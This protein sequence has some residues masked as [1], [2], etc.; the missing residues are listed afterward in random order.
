MQQPPGLEDS[1]FPTHVYKLQRALYGL[2][3]S[4]RGWYAQLSSLLHQLGFVSS[5]VDTCLFIY[6][7][8]D[9][10]LYMLV[11][12]DG[13]VIAGS[14]PTAVDRL[15]QSLSDAFSIKDL[16]VLSYFLGL[17]ASP[18]SGGMMITQRKY[19]LDLLHRVSMENCNST[20]TPLSLTKLLACHT[21]AY[22]G[23]ED[24]FRYRSVVGALQYLT[25]THP[26]ISFV[27]N[28]VCQFLSQP[29]EVH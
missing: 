27:V 9:V 18:N 10:S 7:Q 24:S 22:L 4:P 28:K 12:V 29:T 5:K 26:D 17:E 20:P 8:S 19:A 14:S 21:G 6:S 3:Q 16:G 2:K 15:V 11:Y 25:L 1:Q 13:I 23:T